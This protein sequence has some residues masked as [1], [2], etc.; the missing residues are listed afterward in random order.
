MDRRVVF[1][2]NHR[3]KPASRR[4]VGRAVS[5]CRRRVP[6]AGSPAIP[7]HGPAGLYEQY[8]FHQLTDRLPH[9]LRVNAVNNLY[10]LLVITAPRAVFGMDLLLDPANV[11]FACIVLAAGVAL[12]RKRLFWGL[13]IIITLLTLIL[14]LSVYRYMLQIL[15]LLI[16]GWW[17]LLR[18]I[19]LRFPRRLGNVVFALLLS[20]GA[21]NGGQVIAFIV[22]QCARPFLADY[23]KGIYPP[24][25]QMAHEIPNYTTDRDLILCP[26][27]LARIMEFLADRNFAEPNAS[28]RSNRSAPSRGICWPFSIRRTWSIPAGSA[29]NTLSLK[30]I[31]S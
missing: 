26:L 22:H 10:D 17:N 15:P 7:G 31:F 6:C 27:K 12:I 23:Q 4:S 9:V 24:Y 16:L 13:W 5:R 2:R 20:L 25:V 28:I 30:V 14:L 29:I 11:V 18:S 1:L 21:L 3:P 19:N 8:A